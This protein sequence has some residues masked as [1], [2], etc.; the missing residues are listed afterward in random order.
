MK[1]ATSDEVFEHDGL[2]WKRRPGAQS[3]FAKLAAARSFFLET[4]E[5]A[6][7]NPWLRGDRAA[8]LDAAMAVMQEWTR[9]EPDFRQWTEQET[10]Q[11]L[12]EGDRARA[13]AR[14][15]E[16][17]RWERDKALFNADLFADRRA[18]LEQESIHMH[19]VEELEEVRTGR[20]LSGMVGERRQTEIAEL[21]QRLAAS[22]GRLA[23]LRKSVPDPEA[24]V[25]ER[26]QLPSDRRYSNFLTYKFDREFKVRDLR[27]SLPEL[28]AELK[29]ATDRE[30]RKK[31]RDKVG[32][33]QA[34][35]NYWL[36]V[37]PLTAE[38]MCSECPTPLTG[39][40]WVSRGLHG[41][42]PCPA[43]PGWAARRKKVREMFLEMV[44]RNQRAQTPPAPPKPEPLAVV[45]SGL[46]L[47]EVVERLGELQAQFPN[48]VVKRGRAN[49]WELWSV[50]DS[51]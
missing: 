4:N 39:H 34:E 8:E 37:E 46:P 27:R 13:A 25:S 5:A 1:P 16:E 23:R 47:G 22:E 2:L 43:W 9:A 29:L 40:G 36:A 28:R 51:S 45:P 24:V 18:L 14:A 21:E 32:H 31:L 20:R 10:Q 44:A 19:V 15:E 6:R 49:R 12:D 30:D 48:A 17:A 7:W 11:W 33:E 50:T 38:Q 42:R 3:T 35:L 41:A 26:G